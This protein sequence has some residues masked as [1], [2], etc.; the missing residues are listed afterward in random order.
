VRSTRV[1]GIKNVIIPNV[2]QTLKRF[3]SGRGHL[4]PRDQRDLPRLL[5]LIKGIALLNHRHRKEEKKDIITAI[6]EDVE[7]AFKLYEKVATS[8]ELGL[9]P[10]TYEIYEKVIKPLDQNGGA[11]RKD[12]CKQYWQIFYRPLQD[13]RLRQQILPSLEAAGLIRQEPNPDN[14]RE[15][16]VYPTVPLTISQTGKAHYIQRTTQREEHGRNTPRQQRNSP[17]QM[18]KTPNRH[19][20]RLLRQKT[21]L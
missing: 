18:A 20:M 21:T 6:H 2:D 11:S 17:R 16:L 10:E 14:K 15:L 3:M 4:K 12:I 1:R 9:S 19:P 13:H 8:N 5:R 7:S